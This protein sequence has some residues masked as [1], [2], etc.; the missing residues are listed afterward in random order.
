MDV[1]RVV[2]HGLWQSGLPQFRFIPKAMLK[3]SS[4]T[5]GLE[6]GRGHPKFS[7]GLFDLIDPNSPSDSFNEI[8]TES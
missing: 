8:P 6:Q 5:G 4:S 2:F 1:N 3:D 7:R